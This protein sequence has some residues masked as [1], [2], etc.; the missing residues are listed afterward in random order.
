MFIKVT[1][2][3]FSCVSVKWVELC[4]LFCDCNQ[5]AF[6][7]GLINPLYLDCLHYS[8]IKCQK[9]ESA[10]IKGHR[11]L[12]SCLIF[13]YLVW[14]TKWLKKTVKT[15]DTVWNKNDLDL[16]LPW[17]LCHSS[18]KASWNGWSLGRSFHQTDGW[19]G[20]FCVNI[21]EPDSCSEDDPL[22]FPLAP[23][24][25]QVIIYPVLWFHFHIPQKT[26]I[27]ISPSLSLC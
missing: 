23:S 13:V 10:P 7:C 11:K 9:L 24:S 6:Y 16:I 27:A 12:T 1:A 8:R 25:G 19:A 2:V 18:S 15:F 20:T 22:I 21:P 14:V 17:I 3:L 26:L 4:S 5:Q